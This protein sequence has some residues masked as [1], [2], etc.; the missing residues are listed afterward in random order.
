MN[1]STSTRLARQ[2]SELYQ[3]VNYERQSTAG[4]RSFKLQTM[5]DLMHRLGHPHQFAPVIHVAGTKGK[6]S[7]SKMTGEIL[8]HAGLRT[9]IYS[10]PHLERI[11]QRIAVDDQLISDDQLSDVLDQIQ[12]AIESLDEEFAARNERGLTFFEIITAA[13]FQ[14]FANSKVDAVVLEVGLGGRLDSTNVCQPAVSVITNISLDHTKQLGDTI[15]KI[16][17]EKAG[18][19]KPGVPVVSGALH[20][21]AMEVI[22]DVAADRGA[23]LFQLDR[24]MRTVRESHRTFRCE[25]STREPFE[26]TELECKMPGDHQRANAALAITACKILVD[27]GWEISDDQIRSGIASAMLPGRTE[28]LSREPFVMMDMAHNGASADALIQT[29]IAEVSPESRKRFL[30]ATTR[31]KDTAEIIEP[32]VATADELILTRYQE[33]PRG[34]PIVELSAAVEESISRRRDL[35][36]RFPD[37]QICETPRLAWQY[38]LDSLEQKDAIC[39]AGSAF[40]VAELRPDVM[41]W[42]AQK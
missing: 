16:A 21:E 24:D 40:L 36:Q 13:G 23:H 22:A 5:H 4:P 12:P 10:S 19:I 8:R 17:T 32:L 15:A 27:Q 25:G 3:R 34:K 38:L 35:G 41:A 20:P 6:G 18:I 14:H 39:V 28:I 7:V 1:D 37:V 26:V 42:L 29:L 2:L 33:N 31:D 11:N 9:G 30:V